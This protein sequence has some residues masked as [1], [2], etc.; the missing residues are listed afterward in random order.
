MS[1]L[2]PSESGGGLLYAVLEALDPDLS[3]VLGH[4]LPEVLDP[5]PA[6]RALPA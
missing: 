4:D 5:G 6:G 3:E 2:A 1:R